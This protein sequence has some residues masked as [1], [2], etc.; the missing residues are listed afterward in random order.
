MRLTIRV[1][2]KSKQPGVT[3]SK[4]GSLI[5]AVREAPTGGQANTAVMKAIAEHFGVTP[6]RVRIVRGAASRKK[7]VDVD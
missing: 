4:D 7:V 3:E 5:V 6:S 2:P 1:K